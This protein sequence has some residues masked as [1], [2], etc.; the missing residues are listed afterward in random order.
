MLVAKGN[1]DDG[2]G[3][4]VQGIYFHRIT[5][6][7]VNLQ[8]GE[9][10]RDGTSLAPVPAEMTRLDE[11]TRI[12]GK[13][14]RTC[15]AKGK[16]LGVGIWVQVS[17]ADSGV[18]D[19]CLHHP[20]H[21]ESTAMTTARVE[22]ARLAHEMHDDICLAAGL[23]KDRRSHRVVACIVAAV[24][25]RGGD[26]RPPAMNEQ[27]AVRLGDALVESG[28]QR[29]EDLAL[30]DATVLL[31]VANTL[32]PPIDELSGIMRRLLVCRRLHATASDWV[33]GDVR[34]TLNGLQTTSTKVGG[35]QEEGTDDNRKKFWRQRLNLGGLDM[36]SNRSGS[37]GQ[38]VTNALTQDDEGCLTWL[39]TRY[40]R[41]NVAAVPTKGMHG[42]LGR[43]AVPALQ[44]LEQHLFMD[45]HAEL[46][47]LIDLVELE[48]SCMA[49]GGLGDN[50]RP[51]EDVTLRNGVDLLAHA[52]LLFYQRAKGEEAVINTHPGAC[53]CDPRVGSARNDMR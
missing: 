10:A 27:Q 16:Q 26:D 9:V 24:S 6:F 49:E 1:D 32:H 18:Y 3:T 25:T 8:L 35:L 52:P 39:G 12:L 50:D 30:V 21:S 38:P 45:S 2:G 20:S 36:M 37:E 42:W 31:E 4:F 40:Q 13:Q 34:L 41:C 33:A 17:T 28:C 43:I 48:P 44:K 51:Y 15:S 5:R 23:T 46:F 11:Y 53:V 22:T 29:V 47:L 14:P 19:L 7:S